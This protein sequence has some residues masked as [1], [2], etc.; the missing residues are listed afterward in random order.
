MTTKI[1]IALM[2]FGAIVAAGCA[3]FPVLHTYEETHARVCCVARVALT[4]LATHATTTT[5]PPPLPSP[6]SLSG[7]LGGTRPC[8]PCVEAQCAAVS[9]SALSFLERRYDL[10]FDLLGVCYVLANDVFTS[11]VGVLM[12]RAPCPPRALAAVPSCQRSG[13]VAHV[14]CLGGG[15]HPRLLAPSAGGGGGGGP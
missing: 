13:A 3:P 6:S 9:S 11:L 14:R 7:G 4:P 12:V 5:P 8:L 10:A 15:A 2:V 1:S